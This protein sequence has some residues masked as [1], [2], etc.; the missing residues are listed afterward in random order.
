MLVI[1]V[2]LGL[3]A[4]FVKPDA[5]KKMEIGSMLLMLQ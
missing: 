5:V 4:P 2:A 1:H 3:F